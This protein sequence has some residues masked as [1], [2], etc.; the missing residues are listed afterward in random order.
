[1][2]MHAR[3]AMDA[4]C[5]PD[6]CVLRSAVDSLAVDPTAIRMKLLKEAREFSAMDKKEEEEAPDEEYPV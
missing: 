5:L 3:E 6:L 2:P 1:M 4:D